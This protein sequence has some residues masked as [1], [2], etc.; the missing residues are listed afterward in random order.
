[1]TDLVLAKFLPYRLNHLAAVVSRQAQAVYRAHYDLTMPEWRVLA[2]LGE[3]GSLTAKQIG[4]HSAMHKT[5][6]SRAA[7]SLEA[8]RWL[9]RTVN[10]ADRR[11]EFLVLTRLG[12]AA[13]HEV[14][15]DM[16]AFERAL[17]GRLGAKAAVVMEALAA[18]EAVVGE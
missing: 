15:P 1:M 10:E 14:V 7:A 18:L 2:T 6:V 12:E 17:M 16:L 13:Y 5:K 8:R 4:A 11:E 3:F 9:A